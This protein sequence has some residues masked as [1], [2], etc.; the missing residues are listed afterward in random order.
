M[1]LMPNAATSN[2]ILCWPK[3]IRHLRAREVSCNV[4]TRSKYGESR[5]CNQKRMLKPPAKPVYV[6]LAYLDIVR[7]DATWAW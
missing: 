6:L 4:Q 2:L 1:K 3:T 5:K 7:D